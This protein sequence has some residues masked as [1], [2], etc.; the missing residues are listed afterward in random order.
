[1][2]PTLMQVIPIRLRRFS[3]LRAL[4]ILAGFIAAGYIL[5]YFLLAARR[6]AYPYELEWIEGT[7]IDH[8]RWILQGKALYSEPDIHHIP[9][10]YNPF[11]YYVS[12]AVSKITGVGF[13][14]PRLVSILASGASFLLLYRIVTR[15]YPYPLAGL[16]AAGIFAASY[17]FTGAWMDLAKT[18]SLFLFFTLAAFFL[19]CGPSGWWKMAEA[20]FLFM[21]AF[22]T[23]QLALPI[24][25]CVGLFSLI[26]SQGRTWLAWLVAV[27][28]GGAMF[29]VLDR[30]SSGW[31]SFFTVIIPAYHERVVDV[32]YFWVT[33]LKSWAPAVVVWLISLIAMHS[34]P[35][36]RVKIQE[37]ILYVVF[38]AALIA[39][40]WGIFLKVWTYKNGFLPA[41]LGLALLAGLSVGYWMERS[42]ES[43]CTAWAP[44][45]LAG[46]LVVF[47]WQF[48]ILAYNPLEQIPTPQDRSAG[49]RFI[50]TVAAL[51][52][53]VWIFNHGY[54]S[55]MAGKATYFSGPTFGDVVAGKEVPRGSVPEQR[56]RQ[57][58]DIF[59]QA[60]MEQRFDW[61][62]LD[63]PK[64]DWAP[65]YLYAGAVSVETDA[66]YPVTGAHARPESL[67]VRNPIYHG[68]EMP[69]Q[70]PVYNPLFIKGWSQA[71]DWG[72]WAA[73]RRARV[74]VALDPDTS[75]RVHVD[76]SP[77]CE[78]ETLLVQRMQVG[79]N[80]AILGVR[81][82][83]ACD[84][85][86][87]TFE[88]PAGWIDPKENR[89]WFS[90]SGPAGADENR[91][92]VYALYFEPDNH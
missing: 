57:V 2:R 8:I 28:L 59:N 10:I 29:Y 58:L 46:S 69:L 61:V 87:F 44:R 67:L 12:A 25:L 47:L 6:A 90:F 68:G 75:Y 4:S 45:G 63:E 36:A 54:Y 76:L 78:G 66:F 37:T 40:S 34:R 81:G 82:F 60:R 21:L 72:R 91:A 32:G 13:L 31:F 56:R 24:I 30:A 50:Q 86:T 92:R 80:D 14:A 1:M 41:C 19:V 26:L 89:L 64:A 17:H 49:D 77:A 15:L 22:F 85:Q 43:A 39:V 20:G 79:W 65:Y 70:D 52:G 74:R 62:I 23:K 33:F 84:R 71:Q 3:W 38:S 7:T 83:D 16:I 42:R 11:Y 53:D 9:P 51:P 88:L 27:G 18:D 73:G 48:L 35:G 5:V 55:A